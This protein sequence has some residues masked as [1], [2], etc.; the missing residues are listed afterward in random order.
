M[1]LNESV[2]ATEEANRDE[3]AERPYWDKKSF[4]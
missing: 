4:L 2:G 1:K 3:D